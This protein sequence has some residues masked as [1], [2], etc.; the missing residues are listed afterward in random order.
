MLQISFSFIVKTPF[1]F[2]LSQKEKEHTKT[3]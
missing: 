3:I 1:A 2:A